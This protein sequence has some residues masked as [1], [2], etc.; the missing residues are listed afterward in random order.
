MI[1][2][3]FALLLQVDPDAVDAWY[4]GVYID[5]IE[6]VEMPNT[7]GMSQF[8]DG[9]IVATKPY[10]SSANYIQKMSNYCT[11]CYY[12]HREKTGDRACPFNAL[13]WNFLD[14][15]QEYFKNNR[16]M[17]MML[18]LLRKKSPEEI[19]ALKARAEEI[20]LAP[21]EF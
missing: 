18:N 20:L 5:A 19:A 15:K 2:G 3:N 10:I 12:D 8:A 7:R 21:D 4:L 9:G 16:R 6:W 13:Y 14:E 17:A 11:G 1:I